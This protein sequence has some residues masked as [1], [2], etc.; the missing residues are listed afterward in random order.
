MVGSTSTHAYPAIKNTNTHM[1]KCEAI[2]EGSIP[3]TCLWLGIILVVPK[4]SVK[5]SSS[6]L[7]CQW[8]LSLVYI[9][10]FGGN[11]NT[12]SGKIY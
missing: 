8:I 1:E 12:R 6:N 11:Q 4:L 10:D 7:L 3:I 5:I 9:D 2:D